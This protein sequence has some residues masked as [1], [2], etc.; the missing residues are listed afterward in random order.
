[1]CNNILQYGHV[2]AWAREHGRRSVSMRFCY[3]YK[4]FHIGETRLHNF[5][6]YAT[7]KY[8]AR[9]GLLPV[10]AFHEEGEPVEVKEREMM[11]RRNVIVEGWYV[12]FYDLFL[13][14][15]DEIIGLFAFKPAILAK[16]KAY[17]VDSC[18]RQ[19]AVNLGVHIRRGDYKTWMGG[20]YF[21][22][23]D[24]YIGYIRRFAEL[25]RE[26]NVN[27]FICGND[28]TLDKDKYAGLLQG[29]N[30]RFP[31]GNPGED[32]CLLSECDC[33]MGAPSTF[34]LVAAMY[35]DSPLLW[36]EEADASASDMTFRKFDYLF[37]NIK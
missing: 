33:I 9:L 1:M 12:R 30:V 10:V 3:K 26:R 20:R 15:R 14:Y 23:D 11:R 32:L 27:V 36:I 25:H 28:P 24:T 34:S 37:R 21:F 7:A 29:V 13:K 4:Y 6:T 31:A 19:A 2:Y 18:G 8:M 17:M 5:F 22:D 35:H 16:V